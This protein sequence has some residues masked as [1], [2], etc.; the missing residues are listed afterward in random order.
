MSLNKHVESLFKIRS[1]EISNL[2]D[3]EK[4]IR[5]KLNKNAKKI[6]KFLIN[7]LK[8]QKIRCLSLL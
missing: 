7:F 3:F 5:N 8:K 2:K 4:M 6:D 1:K